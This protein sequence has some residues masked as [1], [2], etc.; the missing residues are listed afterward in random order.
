M[1]RI[2]IICDRWLGFG[3][4]YVVRIDGREVGRLGRKTKE[5]GAD[6]SNGKHSVVV[7]FGG[8]ST[9]P[10]EVDLGDDETASFTLVFGSVAA[11]IG[12]AAMKPLR[13]RI[14]EPIAPVGETSFMA[15]VRTD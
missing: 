2:S 3:T 1:A 11:G 7:A 4:H 13:Q 14:K 6:V 9:A 10:A 8:Q 15:L 5:V 12:L